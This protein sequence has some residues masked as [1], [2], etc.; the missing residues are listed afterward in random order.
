MKEPKIVAFMQNPWF[1]PGTDRRHVDRYT[2]DQEFHRRILAR[3][4][5]GVRLMSA[6]GPAL[7]NAIWWDNVAPTAT[8]E[9]SGISEIDMGHVETALT[10]QRPDLILA[11]GRVAEAALDKSFIA[12]EIP[13]LCCHHTNARGKTMS[14]L[15]E[16]A[17]W[18]AQ[19]IDEW[20]QTL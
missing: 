18:V 17:V 6:L 9:S 3:S 19:W 1:P 8:E 15:S 20:R 11:F 16:F 5:S 7:F 2:T 10:E 14:D 12:M 13:C 4:M